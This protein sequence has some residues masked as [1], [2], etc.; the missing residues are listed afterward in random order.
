LVVEHLRSCDFAEIV[1]LLRRG[2]E[3]APRRAK[4]LLFSLYA[5]LER[6]RSGPA[7]E[8][9]ACEDLS[10]QLAGIP[11][12][13]LGASTE[14]DAIRVPEDAAARLRSLELDVIVHLGARRLESLAPEVSR[15][16]VWSY[17]WSDVEA[18][19][20]GPSG[21]WELAERSPVSGVSLLALGRRPADAVLLARGLASTDPDGCLTRNR[22]KPRMLGSSFVIRKLKE[23]HEAGAVRGDPSAAAPLPPRPPRRTNPSNLEMLRFLAPRLVAKARERLLDVPRRVQWRVAVRMDGAPSFQANGDFNTTG[24]RFIEAPPGH[25]FADPFL[26]RRQGQVYCFF[27]DLDH[28]TGKGIIACAR[29][30][31]DGEL[32]DPRPALERPYHLSYPCVFQEGER[33]YMVPESRRNGTVDLFRATRFPDRWEQVRTLL[34]GPGLDTTVLRHGGRYWFFVTV[35]EPEGAGEQLLLFHSESLTGALCFH[36]GNP[37]SADVRY[38]RSGG[39]IFTDGGRLIRPS[40]DCSGTYG[41]QLHFHQ[42]VALDPDRYREVLLSTIPPWGGL[43]GTHTYNRCGE[44]EVLDGKRLEPVPPRGRRGAVNGS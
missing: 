32:V 23:L 41:R 36:P 1:V 37:I 18:Y 44:V 35:R 9:L 13:D 11:S 29:V 42:I 12:L 7:S 33:V 24:F 38:C 27:E 15:H 22:V 17:R 14:G 31:P 10:G 25:L 30:S 28:A 43:A 34:R 4:A 39:A 19:D 16:G 3:A 20:G 26:L 40:Q 5:A 6:R 2:E 8:L 21:F